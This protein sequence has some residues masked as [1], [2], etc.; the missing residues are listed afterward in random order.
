MKK[1]AE[2]CHVIDEKE[3]TIDSLS[4]PAVADNDPA[5]IDPFQRRLHACY[6]G[7]YVHCMLL[8]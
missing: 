6:I 8:Y 4:D 7:K 2:L 5:S 1:A 3:R